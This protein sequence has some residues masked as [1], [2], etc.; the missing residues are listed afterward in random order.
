M[1]KDIKENYKKYRWFYTSS[2]KIVIG[3]KSA[4]QNDYL[5]SELKKAKED[6]IVLHTS[7]PGSPFSVILS[8]IKKVTKEDTKEAAIFTSCFSQQWKQGKK[9][10]E[11]HLF[12]LSQLSK[13][14]K[15]K[16]GTWQAIGK[17]KNIDVQLELGLTE[18]EGI[19]RAVPISL[20]GNKKN[21]I[22]ITPG[23]MMK[24]EKATKLLKELNNKY[25]KEEILSALP[26]G[27]FS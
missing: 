16:S 18:Q 5:L 27:G 9:K 4:D 6:L 7:S 8:D 12:N 13:Q 3:G 22:K 23:K 25:S 1:Y 14:N 17:I 10:A 11:I 21:L 15:M 19:L 24:E 2:G 26:S 20:I